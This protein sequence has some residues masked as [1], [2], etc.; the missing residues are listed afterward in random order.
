V[1]DETVRFEAGLRVVVIATGT[2]FAVPILKLNV[3]LPVVNEV[4]D[5]AAE[6][7]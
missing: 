6:N 1:L 7:V 4:Q 3:A 2:S 5:A